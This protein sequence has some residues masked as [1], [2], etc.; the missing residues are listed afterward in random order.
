MYVLDSLI[1]RFV[2]VM[3]NSDMLIAIASS[4]NITILRSHMP[5]A[6]QE[7]VFWMGEGDTEK[8][9]KERGALVCFKLFNI[10]FVNVMSNCDMSIPVAGSSYITR[11]PTLMPMACQELVF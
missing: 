3:S 1:F 6:C 8:R 11:P 9:M 5:M 10:N 4:S 2:N 7:L